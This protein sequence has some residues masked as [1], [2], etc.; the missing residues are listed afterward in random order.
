[1]SGAGGPGDG[2]A[3]A[4]RAVLDEATP[5]GGPGIQYVV[6]D[7]DGVVFE[8][9]TGLA[10]IALV[11]LMDDHRAVGPFDDLLGKVHPCRLQG[12]VGQAVDGHAGRDLDPQTGIAGYRQEAL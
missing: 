5:R 3:L 8:H 11:T 9:T 4:A 6:V 12:R 2:A 7:A 10:D 1:M